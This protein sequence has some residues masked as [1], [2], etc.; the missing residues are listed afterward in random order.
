MSPIRPPLN[1]F[2]R[3]ARSE[4]GLHLPSRFVPGVAK[5]MHHVEKNGTA[6]CCCEQP[7]AIPECWAVAVSGFSDDSCEN[8]S[9]LNKTWYLQRV[10]ETTVWSCT[11]PDACTECGDK[12]ISLSI[13]EDDDE[14]TVT[15]NGVTWTKSVTITED[16][17]CE[18]H[19]LSYVSNSGDCDHDESDVTITPGYN[20]NGICPCPIG[21][22]DA[23]QEGTLFLAGTTPQTLNV[24]FYGTTDDW[25]SV[26]ENYDGTYV[27]EQS[28]SSACEWCYNAPK[29][30]GSVSRWTMSVEIVISTIY[31][32]LGQTSFTG[33][34]MASQWV[35]YS[36]SFAET[37]PLDGLSFAPVTVSRVSGATAN[38]CNWPGT[39]TVY[40]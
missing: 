32:K 35:Y 16:S 9:V 34:S 25:C 5:R 37:E 29:I 28:P 7:C 36:G 33:C 24:D 13:S 2:D 10:E 18:S 39:A 14:I 23:C 31:L 6:Q 22:G 40:L 12:T 1:P 27:L 26:C 8:C 4:S 15:F 20:A 3:W 21:C 19:D 30:C 38:G 17:Y 11:V